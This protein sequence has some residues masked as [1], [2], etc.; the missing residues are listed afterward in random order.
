[1]TAE[2]LYDRGV[3]ATDGRCPRPLDVCRSCVRWSPVPSVVVCRLP[4]TGRRPLVVVQRSVAVRWSPSNGRSPT[5]IDT[6]IPELET[7]E[8]ELQKL[9]F[10]N[11]F[12]HY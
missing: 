1:M 4:S 10:N 3:P 9:I 5:E 7:P 11:Q 2:I 6:K 12:L 8:F